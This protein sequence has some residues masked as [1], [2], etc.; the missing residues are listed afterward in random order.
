MKKTIRNQ[1]I[2]LAGLTQA[3]YLVKQIAK[4]GVADSGPTETSIGTI[5][6]IDAD[7]IEEVFGGLQNIQLGLQQLGRQL[8]GRETIDPELARYAATLVYLERRLRQRPE[9]LRAIRTGVEKASAQAETGSAIDEHVLEILADVYQNTVSRMNPRV[10]ISGDEQ[11]L[12]QPE[13]ANKI[14][15]LL[16]AGIRSA[17]LWH[18]SGGSR[19]K[20]IL[21]RGKIL[22]ET[23]IL[24]NA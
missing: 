12:R 7:S 14:R 10:L 15:S 18:Q 20:F 3:V 2:A 9:L 8:A 5:L 24:Q 23:R 21:F 17:V 11:H 1:T 16:L 19:W 4:S 6:R 13:N 22:Q